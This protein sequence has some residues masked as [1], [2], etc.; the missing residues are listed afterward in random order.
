MLPKPDRD[1]NL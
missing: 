1:R